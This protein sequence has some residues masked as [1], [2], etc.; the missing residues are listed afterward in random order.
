[1]S[2]PRR[3]FAEARGSGLTAAYLQA[4]SD[5][6]LSG[7]EGAQAVDALGTFADRL[8]RRASSAAPGKASAAALSAHLD[9]ANGYGVR[10]TTYEVDGR[11]QVCYEGEASRRLLAMPA[12]DAAQRARAAL[13][14]TRPECV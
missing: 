3:L 1:M 5:K 6:T 2:L 7:A 13:A 14:L 11:M 8:A 4:A 10:F 12:A 9:V